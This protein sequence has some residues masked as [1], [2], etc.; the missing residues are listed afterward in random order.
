MMA[1]ALCAQAQAQQVQIQVVDAA[2]N[3]GLDD[4]NITLTRL[5]FRAGDRAPSPV[6]CVTGDSGY[7]RLPLLPSARYTLTIERKGYLLERDPLLSRES[8]TFAADSKTEFRVRVPMIRGALMTGRVYDEKGRP[9]VGALL[10]LQSM[11]A[12]RGRKRPYMMQARAGIDGWFTFDPIPPGR[13]GLSIIPPSSIRDSRRTVDRQS[14]ETIGYPVHLWHT[15]IEE[16]HFVE[17]VDTWPGAELRNRLVVIRSMRLFS[18]TGQLVD[19][20][21]RT[22]IRDARVTLRTAGDIQDVVFRGSAVDPETGRFD[23]PELAPGDYELLIDRG[24]ARDSLPMIVPVRIDPARAVPDLHLTLPAWI[25]VAMRLREPTR[26]ESGDVSVE[27]VHAA[28][29]SLS[30]RARPVGHSDF[31]VGPLPPG[32]YKVKVTPPDPYWIEAAV[33]GGSN[34]LSDGLKL[35]TPQE[36]PLVLNINAGAARLKG[37]VFD[38]DDKPVGDGV[39][40]AIPEDGARRRFQGAIRTARILPTGDYELNGLPPGTYRLVALP[41]IPD[42]TSDAPR[43][44][45]RYRTDLLR[46]RLEPDARILLDLPVA[47]TPAPTSR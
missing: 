39:V 32:E 40:L 11:S 20:R 23:F 37:R 34:V 12:S 4:A 36:Q 46:I 45:A 43:I 15:G 6:L 29:P 8:Y 47:A 44:E 41:T 18:I 26:L 27:V 24:M 1:A 25:P 21:T 38:A 5:S 30:V 2:G 19:E 22:P 3:H 7:C 14:G 17:P 10:R 13:F 31:R 28:D 9:A 16:E 33:W 35:V 42:D